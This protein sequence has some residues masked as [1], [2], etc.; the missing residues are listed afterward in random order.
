MTRATITLNRWLSTS[1]SASCTVLVGDL[2]QRDVAAVGVGARP[3]D[4]TSPLSRQAR[5]RNRSDPPGDMSA[6]SMSSSG[7]PAK[8]RVSRTASTPNASMLLPQV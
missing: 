7:G 3:R 4:V 8:T 2:A 1:C 5:C 6:Q